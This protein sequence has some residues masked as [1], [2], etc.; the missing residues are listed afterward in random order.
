[1]STQAHSD[2]IINIASLSETELND[3][4]VAASQGLGPGFEG[5]REWL[6]EHR[7]ELQSGVC[8]SNLVRIYLESEHARNRIQIVAGVADVI[9]GMITGI[10]ALLVAEL[11]VREG[12]MSFC[13]SRLR[14][15]PPR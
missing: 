7:D 6:R 8:N 13:E 10:A 2:L 4:F 3:Q 5:I 9:S 12:L 15:H 14:A 1:M 11:I